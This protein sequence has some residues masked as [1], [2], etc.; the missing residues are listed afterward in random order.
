MKLS[1][2]MNNT[3]DSFQKC[4]FSE[5]CSFEMPYLL[6]AM[7]QWIGG[8]HTLSIYVHR[9]LAKAIRAVIVF[10]VVLVLM[11][12]HQVPVLNYIELI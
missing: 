8:Y 3:T 5:I 10:A 11:L 6:I 4:M 7:A 9:V 1:P 2:D 12:Q